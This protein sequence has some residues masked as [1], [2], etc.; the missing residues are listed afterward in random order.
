[1][2]IKVYGST[3]KSTQKVRDWF[4]KYNLAYMYRDIE[5]DPLTINEMKEVLSLTENGTDDVL[6]VKSNIYKELQLDI[7]SLSLHELL[8][9]IEIHPNLLRKP[10]SFTKD[11]LQV[12]FNDT[13]RKFIP[14]E[15]RQNHLLTLLSTN[16]NPQIGV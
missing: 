12:G 8:E 2:S 5:E 7:A 9:Y 10:I 15:V 3:C 4:E 13:I 6:S 16:L 1:M 11:K 14:K